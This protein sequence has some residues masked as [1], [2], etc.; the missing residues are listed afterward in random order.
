MTSK[1]LKTAIATAMLSGSDAL[2]NRGSEQSAINEHNRKIMDK[3]KS[4]AEKT[5]KADT[6][7]KRRNTIKKQKSLMKGS[8]R[9]I[10]DMEGAQ[11]MLANTVI[12]DSLPLPTILKRGDIVTYKGKTGRP[13]PWAERQRYPSSAV[14]IVEVIKP[15]I[16]PPQYLVANITETIDDTRPGGPTV[17]VNHSELEGAP[18]G[19]NTLGLLEEW[20]KLDRDILHD[21]YAADFY[22]GSNLPGA[23]VARDTEGLIA[24]NPDMIVG[25][26]WKEKRDLKYGTDR[27]GEQ[28]KKTIE[29][30]KKLERE[31]KKGTKAIEDYETA[32]YLKKAEK[33]LSPYIGDTA[34]SMAVKGPL[35]VASYLAPQVVIPLAA[36]ADYKSRKDRKEFMDSIRGNIVKLEENRALEEKKMRDLYDEYHSVKK[37]TSPRYEKDVAIPMLQTKHTQKMEKKDRERREQKLKKIAEEMDADD[38][39]IEDDDNIVDDDEIVVNEDVPEETLRKKLQAVITTHNRRAAGRRKSRRPQKQK[40]RRQ[41]KNKHNNTRHKKS[42]KTKRR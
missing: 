32:S 4:F 16:G 5:R 10:K 30:T 11:N 17:L 27:L 14:E 33:G 18:L 42:R 38:E 36:A 34:A 7:R 31:I 1:A 26:T 39:D 21:D 9:H 23:R 6:D 2:W 15:T 25:P 13:G 22:R 40:S 28:R 19:R 29:A 37:T 41:H 35:G 12:Q 8:M 20:E 24:A 3:Q